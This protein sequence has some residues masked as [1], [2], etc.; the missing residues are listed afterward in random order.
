MQTLRAYIK[1]GCPYCEAL[2][3]AASTHKIPVEYVQSSDESY[4]AIRDKFNYRTFPLITE[5]DT[6]LGGYVDFANSLGRLI[7]DYATT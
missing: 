7:R 1:P 2:F 3:D 6:L 4:P 5:G